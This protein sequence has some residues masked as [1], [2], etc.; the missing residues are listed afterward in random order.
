[1]LNS[2]GGRLVISGNYDHDQWDDLVR[3]EYLKRQTVHG[4]PDTYVYL[5]TD[6][7]RSALPSL[8]YH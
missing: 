3:N 1:V 6:K 7:G 5:I 2:E 8:T 4:A